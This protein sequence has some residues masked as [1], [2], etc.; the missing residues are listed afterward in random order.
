MATV[1]AIPEITVFPSDIPSGE[2]DKSLYSWKMKLHEEETLCSEDHGDEFDSIIEALDH[3]FSIFEDL[4]G[5]R[6]VYPASNAQEFK[7]TVMRS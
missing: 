2:A 7:L 4:V 3:A 6:H 5:R 1:L